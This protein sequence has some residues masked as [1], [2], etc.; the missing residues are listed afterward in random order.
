[1]KTRE[2]S[3]EK[4]NEKRCNEPEEVQQKEDR[5]NIYK[6]IREIAT[7][8]EIHQ[9]CILLTYNVKQTIDSEKKI[10]GKLHYQGK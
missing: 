1:M 2:S 10:T 5:F 8:A 3:V 6:R 4:L 7:K 9:Q